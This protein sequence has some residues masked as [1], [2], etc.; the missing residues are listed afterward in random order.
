MPMTF[1]QKHMK[2]SR[3]L[4][5]VAK[6]TT[7]AIEKL[8]G[9]DEAS[10]ISFS[11]FVWHNNRD[12]P[13]GGWSSYIGTCEREEMIPVLEAMLAR[14]KAGEGDLERPVHERN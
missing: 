2:L 14:W 9:K 4:Q 8:M 11:M 7:R 6:A 12:D 1:M 10:Q 5:D 3:G 13:K